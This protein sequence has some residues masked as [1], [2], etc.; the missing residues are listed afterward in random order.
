[1][2]VT[3]LRQHPE[4]ALSVKKITSWHKGKEYTVNYIG[5]PKAKLNALKIVLADCVANGLIEIVSINL[6]LTGETTSETFKRI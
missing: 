6:A 2:T 1:M 5:I 3:E 4:Y